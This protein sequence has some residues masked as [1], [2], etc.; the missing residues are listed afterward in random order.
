MEIK[1]TEEQT[2]NLKTANEYETIKYEDGDDSDEMTFLKPYLIE[3]VISHELEEIT[4]NYIKYLCSSGDLRTEEDI[5]NDAIP[6]EKWRNEP[7]PELTER[8]PVYP[9]SLNYMVDD[10]DYSELFAKAGINLDKDDEDENE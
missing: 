7:I 2:K 1:L 3:R 4:Q 5:K 6:K 9:E 10:G 8:E